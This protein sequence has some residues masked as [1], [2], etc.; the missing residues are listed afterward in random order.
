MET[1]MRFTSTILTVVLLASSPSVSRAAEV[2]KQLNE[3]RPL[4][5]LIDELI[6]EGVSNFEQRSSPPA[7]MRSFSVEFPWT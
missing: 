5:E 7:V 2:G 4:H 1:V 3:T 6:A